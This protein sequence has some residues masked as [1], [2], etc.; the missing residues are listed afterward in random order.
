MTN[1]PELATLA[2]ELGF[3]YVS[4]VGGKSGQ[5]L[6]LESEEI[7][8]AVKERVTAGSPLMLD[9]L[10][11]YLVRGSGEATAQPYIELLGSI[12]ESVRTR[13]TMR[14]VV[15]GYGDHLDAPQKELVETQLHPPQVREALGF[16]LPRQ[17]YEIYER[18]ELK[19]QR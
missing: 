11:C 5:D 4:A 15:A 6:P 16:Q 2:E 1:A 3:G 19:T 17:S 12:A 10:F 8:S 18:E 9:V 7:V 14:V 13:R